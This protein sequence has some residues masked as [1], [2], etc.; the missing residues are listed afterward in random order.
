MS[1][2][3]SLLK[4]RKSKTLFAVVSGTFL[5]IVLFFYQAYQIPTELSFSGHS[6]LFRAFCFGSAT[7]LTFYGLEIYLE[8]K[9]CSYSIPKGSQ[10]IFIWIVFEIISGTLINFILFNIFW[11]WVNLSWI[12]FGKMVL[13]FTG[14]FIIPFSIGLV[15]QMYL[16]NNKE[17]TPNPTQTY[18]TF[19]SSNNKEKI[20]LTIDDLLFIKSE[21][22]YVNVFYR[23]H[24]TIER[25][26]I[27]N[28]LQNIE[29]SYKDILLQRCHRSYIVN[30]KNVKAV[31]RKNDQ[32]LLVIDEQ[33]QIP[34]S[35]KYK[36]RI[37]QLVS[38]KFSHT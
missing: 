1:Q 31:H 16:N 20:A 3:L 29:R 14:V 38:E 33:R 34:V 11:N 36:D 30:F 24:G 9:L 17:S 6:L 13:E 22:N 8:P 4:E 7:F 15:Y 23:N 25:K 37:E 12:G 2:K 35:S 21:D 19:Q 32:I 26:L 27:R 5:F 18:L 28:T 10:V